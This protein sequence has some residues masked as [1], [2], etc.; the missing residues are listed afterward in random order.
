[1]SPHHRIQGFTVDFVRTSSGV[2]IFLGGDV[3]AASAEALSE[4]L[5]SCLPGPGMSVLVDL[6]ALVLLDAAGSRILGRFYDRARAAGAEFSTCKPQ[7]IVRLVL[8]I[9]G[10]GHTIDESYS[11][12][13]FADLPAP[14]TRQMAVGGLR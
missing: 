9:A 1:V 13:G 7:P 14:P 11:V 5:K 2:E 8:D 10:L 3:D 4:Q 12:H 6:G